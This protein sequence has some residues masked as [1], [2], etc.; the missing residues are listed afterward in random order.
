VCVCVWLRSL[1]P[2]SRPYTMELVHIRFLQTT[3][4]SDIAIAWTSILTYSMGQKLTGFQLVKK[5]PAFYGTQRFITVVTCARH[6]SL[7]GA[8]NFKSFKSKRVF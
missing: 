1:G 4:L 3:R 5:F 2:V 7:S 6:L 8:K